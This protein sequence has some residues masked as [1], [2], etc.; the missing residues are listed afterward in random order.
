MS[1][2]KDFVVF[3]LAL[4]RHHIQDPADHSLMGAENNSIYNN[5]L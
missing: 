3:T 4:S 1:K 2:V 5:A